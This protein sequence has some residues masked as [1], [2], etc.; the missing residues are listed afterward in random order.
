ME[1]TQQLELAQFRAN[2]GSNSGGG[3]SGN[4][5]SSSPGENVN[6]NIGNGGWFNW[7]LGWMWGGP[8]WYSG[9]DYGWWGANIWNG[10]RN[11]WGGG[12]WN[13]QGRVWN[14]GYNETINRNRSTEIDSNRNWDDR[15]VRNNDADRF[16][17]Q[18]NDT[19]RRDSFRET[20]DDNRSNEGHFQS[21]GGDN[22]GGRR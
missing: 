9:P 20:R 18:N 8:G 1:R 10:W 3:S 5:D 16:R 17:D 19:E 2:G 11:W 12:N 7:A 4:S 21:G 6:I 15:A 13:D 22:H 14:G